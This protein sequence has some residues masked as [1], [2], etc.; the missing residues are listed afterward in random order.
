[1]SGLPTIRR[2]SLRILIQ[3]PPGR[4]VLSLA[5]T[6][7]VRVARATAVLGGWSRRGLSPPHL[8]REVDDLAPTAG[9]PVATGS[10]GCRLP[11]MACSVSGSS[12]HV[13]V[14]VA[15]GDGAQAQVSPP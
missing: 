4:G 10:C 9:R 2:P 11:E 5:R 13:V 14:Y 15:Q 8:R 1:M 12:L 6:G 3:H 7:A